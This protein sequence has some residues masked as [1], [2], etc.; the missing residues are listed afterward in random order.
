MKSEEICKFLHTDNINIIA[1]Y[2]RMEFSTNKA[3][4]E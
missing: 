2:K 4:M 3:P 1:D